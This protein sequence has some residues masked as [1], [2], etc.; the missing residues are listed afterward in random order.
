MSGP[1]RSMLDALQERAKELHCLYRVHEICGRVEAPLDE[2]FREVA[3]IIPIGWQYPPEC[4]VRISVGRRSTRPRSPSRPRGSRP[5]R[6]G[7]RAR[8]SGASRSTT[9]S[10]SRPRTRGRS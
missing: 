3:A 9:G 2:I 8:S 10:S 7:S 1:G 5:P 6:S 4:F